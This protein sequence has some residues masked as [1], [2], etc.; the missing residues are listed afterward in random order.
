[1][2]EWGATPDDGCPEM[3]DLPSVPGIPM[4]GMSAT[5][6]TISAR[7]RERLRAREEA[8]EAREA[9]RVRDV[10]AERCRCL[11][12]IVNVRSAVDGL[13]E[14]APV[15]GRTAAVGGNDGAGAPPAASM[16]RGATDSVFRRTGRASCWRAG[17]RG[18]TERARSQD[19]SR[20]PCSVRVPD[21][22]TLFAA[23]PSTPGQT[24]YLSRAHAR[25]LRGRYASSP[26]R[27]LTQPAGDGASPHSSTFRVAGLPA[28]VAE[29]PSAPEIRQLVFHHESRTAY[30]Q[31]PHNPRRGLVRAALH[32]PS[33]RPQL[34]AHRWRGP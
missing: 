15:R 14:P 32:A 22:E 6:G 10:P 8:L 29:L 3:E 13:V 4:A 18:A 12:Q 25:R 28:S 2:A 7:D 9:A 23:L 27:P 30:L 17:G 21:S 1:M 5:T 26:P 19:G 31:S 11:Q 34:P 33:R 24:R 20:R 16:V